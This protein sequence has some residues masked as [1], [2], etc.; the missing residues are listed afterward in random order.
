MKLL[1]VL[2]CLCLTGCAHTKETT[3][4]INGAALGALAGQIITTS[5]QGTLIGVAVGTAVGILYNLNKPDPVPPGLTKCH[6][7][8]KREYYPDGSYAEK[9]TERCD[10]KIE[11]YGY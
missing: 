2:L 3:N 11:L 9:V 6:K 7:I 8:I 1:C 10:G 4:V 5:T